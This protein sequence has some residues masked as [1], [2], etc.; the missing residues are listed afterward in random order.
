MWGCRTAAECMEL[1]TFKLDLSPH[2]LPCLR[3][4]MPPA[5]SRHPA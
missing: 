5:C 1:L 4:S 3:R 2:L